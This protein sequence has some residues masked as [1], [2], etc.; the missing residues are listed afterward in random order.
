MLAH[1]VDATII[2][3]K[4]TQGAKLGFFDPNGRCSQGP[5]AHASESSFR[6]MHRVASHHLGMQKGDVRHGVA[7]IVKGFQSVSILFCVSPCHK[8][9]T[10]TCNMQ[11]GKRKRKREGERER[12]ENHW[13]AGQQQAGI[14]RT[15]VYLS[16]VSTSISF[17]SH[18]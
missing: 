5:R 2:S 17:S 12:V 14:R 1:I 7:T 13:N 8:A 4:R 10:H 16:F 3:L 15:Y 9:R 11:G 18:S 6:P